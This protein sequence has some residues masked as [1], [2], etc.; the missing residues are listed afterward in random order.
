MSYLKTN[1]NL[2][3]KEPLY[4]QFKQF[5]LVICSNLCLFNISRRE[6]WHCFSLLSLK[7]Y[8][9]YIDASIR[10][11]LYIAYLL[12]TNQYFRY[13]LLLLS[14]CVRYRSLW[15]FIAINFGYVFN[16]VVSK[17]FIFILLSRFFSGVLRYIYFAKKRY[18]WKLK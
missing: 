14:N 15:T 9:I 10:C 12:Q 7:Y 18:S 13:E 16:N 4:F 5:M 17:K 3:S 6:N 11:P 1:N 2:I 8:T